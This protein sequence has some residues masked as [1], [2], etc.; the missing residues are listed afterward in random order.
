[1]SKT[2]VGVLAY[3]P[4]ISGQRGYTFQADRN[5]CDGQCYHCHNSSTHWEWDHIRQMSTNF[6]YTQLGHWT[7]DARREMQHH[8]DDAWNPENHYKCVPGVINLRLMSHQFMPPTEFVKPEPYDF[9]DSLNA[10]TGL[11]DLLQSAWPTIINGGWPVFR[12]VH[13]LARRVRAVYLEGTFPEMPPNPCDAMNSDFD[14]QYMNALNYHLATG[15]MPPT[16]ISMRAYLL[17]FISS[18]VQQIL[19]GALK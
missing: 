13:L 12:E 8:M 2:I 5:S 3:I 1:M 16:D 19:I 6:A 9:L 14:R 4:L 15:T 11:L 10:H 7:D 18:S 17:I